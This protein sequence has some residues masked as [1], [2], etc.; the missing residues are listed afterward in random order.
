MGLS[1]FLKKIIEGAREGN[2]IR[3]EYQ[4]LKKEPPARNRSTETFTEE[5]F[6][7]DEQLNYEL[8]AFVLW[9]YGDDKNDYQA[10]RRSLEDL[11]DFVLSDRQKDRLIEKLKLYNEGIERKERFKSIVAQAKELVNNRQQKEAYKFVYE[12]YK[13][14]SSDVNLAELITQIAGLFSSEDEVLNIYDSLIAVN[15]RDSYNIKY[16]KALYLKAKQRFNEAIA[17]FEQLNLELEFAWNYYQ[18]AI[19][20]NLIGNTDSCLKLLKKTFALDPRLKADAKQYPELANL[21]LEPAFIAV[22]E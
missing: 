6:D 5:R 11:E 14:D 3:E 19:M 8:M 20:E 1:Q 18:M 7:N 17:V 16:R 15:P 21:Q 9:K 10:T 12:A 4:I 2:P 22:V 13:E